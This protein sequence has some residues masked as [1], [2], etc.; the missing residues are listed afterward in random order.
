MIT[1]IIWILVASA[2]G[3]G[4]TA[5]FSGWLK[6]QRNVFLLIYIP[7]VAAFF[8]SFI[9]YNDYDV[10][11]LIL[12]NWYWGVAGAVL[13]SAFVIKNVLS[14][15]SSEH[16]KGITLLSDIIWPGFAYG[17]TDSLLLS[18]L[19]VLSVQS[20]LISTGWMEGWAGKI[21]FGVIAMFASFLVTAIYHWGYHE[22]RGK[23]V[24]WPMIGNGVLS[25]AY[26]LTGNPLAAILPH[27]GMHITAMIHGRETTG[28]VPPHYNESTVNPLTQNS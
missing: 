16:S 15:P 1:N 23:K 20:A 17:L 18:V 7:L 8:I 6:L 13:A 12:N 24:I 9:I 22:F 5:I 25:L 11:D 10:K 4:I 14:Q 2:L 3:F 21:G 27:I 28:Q 26:I 19:P